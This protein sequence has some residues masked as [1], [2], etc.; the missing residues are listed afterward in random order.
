MLNSMSPCFSSKWWR[1]I[2][3]IQ[4]YTSTRTSL[5]YAK[6]AVTDLTVTIQEKQPELKVHMSSHVLLNLLNELGKR[7]KMW[8]LSS[9]LSLFR[10]KFKTFN[11]TRA[12]MLD[13]IYHMTSWRSFVVSYYE[14]VTFPLVSWVR[15]GTWLYWFL[16]FA[17]LLTSRLLWNPISAVKTLV[18]CHYVCN[19]IM[20]VI[21]FPENL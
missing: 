3:Y 17:P 20:D 16:I 18:F 2:K 14:F 5:I 6:L 7:D 1:T 4:N 11:K 15:C 8:G 19:I 9:I 21:M 13:S 12:Q 10:N